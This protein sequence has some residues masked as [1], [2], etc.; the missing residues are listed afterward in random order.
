MFFTIS[1]RRPI[2]LTCL[3]Q[4]PVACIP[5]FA[6]VS[7]GALDWIPKPRYLDCLAQ[8]PIACMPGVAVVSLGTQTQVPRLRSPVAN[9]LNARICR[10][11]HAYLR[12]GT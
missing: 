7:L 6:V 1:R 8:V 2:A 11:Q 3:A 4:L 10:R 12:L 9:S 5:G